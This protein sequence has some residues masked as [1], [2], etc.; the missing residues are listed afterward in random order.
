MILAVPFNSAVHMTA[1]IA[2]VEGIDGDSDVPTRLTISYS[3]DT[4]LALWRGLNIGD[5]VL[6][7]TEASS[8]PAV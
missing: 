7:I 8:S 6:E 4:E 3:T 2:G 5:E 1:P